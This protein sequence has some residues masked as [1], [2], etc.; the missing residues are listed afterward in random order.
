[1][2]GLK[3][4]GQLHA[5][6]T[7]VVIT[8]LLMVQVAEGQQCGIAICYV[9]TGDLATLCRPL[10]FCML[11]CD[12]CRCLCGFSCLLPVD[13]AF[14]QSLISDIAALAPAFA[15]LQSEV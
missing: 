9:S 11:S 10:P 12:T 8:C 3:T 2:G 7:L 1:M 15:G 14:N 6:L 13:L 5:W 4:Q